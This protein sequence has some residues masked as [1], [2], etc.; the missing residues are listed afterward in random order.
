MALWWELIAAYTKGVNR[1]RRI[2]RGPLTSVLL[3]GSAVLLLLVAARYAPRVAPVRIPG[4]ANGKRLML[5]YSVGGRPAPAAVVAKAPQKPA[6]D[7]KPAVAALSAPAT[8]DA[9]AADQ[10]SGTSGESALGNGNINIASLQTHPRPQPD[11]SSLAHGAGGQ[12]IMNAVIDEHGRIS[13][14]TLVQG[15]GDGIDETVLAT[16]RGWLFNP[17]TKD[18]KPIASEQEILLYY[19]RG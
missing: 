9:H 16:V 13:Q 1:S 7:P 2:V 8:P 19:E 3:H 18:G 10:G 15:L 11:L 17:A 14:L 5:T 4:T 6:E 12:V